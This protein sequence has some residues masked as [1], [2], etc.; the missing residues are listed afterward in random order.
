MH[1]KTPSTQQAVKLNVM[2]TLSF[3]SIYTFEKAAFKAIQ[4]Q[5]GSG[6]TQDLCKT[7]K[8]MCFITPV[9]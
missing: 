1:P 6:F 7:I 3:P 5:L 4:I 8:F 2:Q 9:H